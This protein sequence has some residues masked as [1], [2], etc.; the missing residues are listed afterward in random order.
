MFI[1]FPN[2]LKQNQI[3]FRLNTDDYPSSKKF[4]DY[5]KR[6]KIKYSESKHFSRIKLMGW[7]TYKIPYSGKEVFSFDLNKKIATEIVLGYHVDDFK[8]KIACISFLERESKIDIDE[9]EIK[10]NEI[11]SLLGNDDNLDLF[12][13]IEF[14]YYFDGYTVEIINKIKSQHKK[15]LDEIERLVGDISYY[16]NHNKLF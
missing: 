6:N 7:F 10:L 12:K 8:R 14:I 9:Y 2:S 11:L 15:F 13:K 3:K 1:T 16:F 5:L 4:R